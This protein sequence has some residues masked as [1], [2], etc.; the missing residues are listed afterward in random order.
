MGATKTGQQEQGRAAHVPDSSASAP[1]RSSEAS[2]EIKQ[3]LIQRGKVGSH[4]RAVA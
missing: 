2:S 1:V 3:Q 4:C